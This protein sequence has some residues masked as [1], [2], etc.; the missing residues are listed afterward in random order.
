[1][2]VEAGTFVPVEFG[3]WR[4]PSRIP[5]F[6][7]RGTGDKTLLIIKSVNERGEPFEAKLLLNS[8]AVDLAIH[9]LEERRSKDVKGLRRVPGM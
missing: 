1:M 4:D 7:I 8:N 9:A 2:G 3:G 5:E 6:E